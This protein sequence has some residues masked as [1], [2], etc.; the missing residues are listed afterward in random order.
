MKKLLI[1]GAGIYQVPLIQ[2]AKEMGLYTIVASIP[3]KY[4]GFALADRVVYE[5]TVDQE[6]MLRVAREE[7]VDGVVVCGT[8]VCVPTQG[9]L[10]DT[11]GLTGPSLQA[12]MAAQDKALMKAAFAREGVRTARFVYAD[13]ADANPQALCED[14]GYPVIFKSVDSS[15]SRGITRV[16]GPEDIPYA[17]QQVREN[18]RSDRYLI[19]EFLVGE[20]FGA[21][22]FIYG[23]RLR[24][25]LP[26][27]DYVFHGDTGVPVGHFAP[28]NMGPDIV[29]DAEEQ[30]QKAVTAMGI[31]NCAINADFILCRGKAYVL[32]I[33]ARAG[34]TCLVEMTGIYYGFDYY[35]KIIQASLGVEPDFT[36]V[37]EH[38][39]PNAE[40][41]FQSD[42]T[43]TITS[44]DL[45]EQDDPRIVNLS[46][47]YGV[48]DHIRKFAKGPDRIGQIIAVADS[49]EEAKAALDAA[50]AKVHIT[51]AEDWVS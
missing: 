43:G 35:E 15:G 34:A 41:L 42:K 5:N 37:L 23:G 45:G 9:Y 1:L 20:E 19:E 33:G 16:D 39:Q 13:I 48:G 28:Y 22:A 49:V 38:G 31:D 27:G 6:A 29:A 47:D 51:V 46:M 2:K 12:A 11:L 21:Q 32:E 40:M 3:G 17:Y 18:T 36:P 26:H 14:I 30:L 50:M 8:D 7:Q 24:F 10:C 44:I 4:P 25:V